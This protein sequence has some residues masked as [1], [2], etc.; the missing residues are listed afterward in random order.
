MSDAPAGSLRTIARL[1][2]ADLVKLSRYWVVVAGFAAIAV[3]AVPGAAL[4]YLLEQSIRV[5]SSSGYDFAVN[6]M[7]RYVD[8]PAP[9]LFVV[10]CIVFAIDVANSTLKYLLTRPVTRMELLLAKCGTA[11][12]LVLCT[13]A[14]LWAAALGAGAWYYGLGDLTENDYV[15][16]EAAYVWRQILV[17]TLFL[18]VGYMALAAMGIMVSTWSST[19]GG[20]VIIGL[21]LYLFFQTVALIPAT[22]GVPLRV[23][24]EEVVLSVGTLGFVSQLYVPL[25][26]LAELGTGIPIDDWW[27][28]EVQRFVLT[29]LAFTGF[30]FAIAAW[31][32]HRRDFAL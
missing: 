11:A 27:S 6:L 3:I 2:R 29:S 9:I 12:V 13:V 7:I 5:T 18:L 22:L 16:F 8:L 23:G 28:W 26:R 20:A 32:I 14:L 25:Y 4:A 17:G 15:I 10:I 31:R 30:F 19:M 21:I 1:V 24:G